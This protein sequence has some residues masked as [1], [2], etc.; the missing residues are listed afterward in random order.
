MRSA[1]AEMARGHAGRNLS[2][3]TTES[4]TS[5][6]NQGAITN[7]RVLISWP[8]GPSGLRTHDGPKILCDSGSHL[9][10]GYLPNPCYTFLHE[11]NIRRLS[12]PA[13]NGNEWSVGYW[14]R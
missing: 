12:W 8:P 9:R 1:L 13:G 10:W 5:P 7:Q 11:S 3:L 6:R 14:T 2:N 4:K